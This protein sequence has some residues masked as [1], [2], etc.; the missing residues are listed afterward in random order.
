M[1][2]GLPEARGYCGGWLPVSLAGGPGSIQ[3]KM[4]SD[5]DITP[6]LPGVGWGCGAGGAAGDGLI[7]GTF[8]GLWSQAAQVPIPVPSLPSWAN[9]GEWLNGLE[10]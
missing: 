1:P 5:V 10:P 2:S 7:Q 9:L 6:K 8:R 4:S 3:L